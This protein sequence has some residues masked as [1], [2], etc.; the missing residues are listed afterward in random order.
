MLLHVMLPK[1]SGHEICAGS[2]YDPALAPVKVLPMTARSFAI[3]RRKDL[4]GRGHPG[5][6]FL[7]KKSCP[8]RH[9]AKGSTG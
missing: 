4:I 2:R 9:S 1:I 3:A 6:R 5:S 7:V 8:I